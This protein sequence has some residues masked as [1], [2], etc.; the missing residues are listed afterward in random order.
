MPGADN[1][2]DEAHPRVGVWLA[3]SLGLL[4]TLGP[5]GTDTYLASLPEMV[6]E[7][8]S[9]PAQGQLTLTVFLLAMG[10]GSWPP[11]PSSMPAADDGPCCWL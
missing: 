6:D 10:S 5:A 2:V 3:F 1:D 9:T 4:T 7:L 11:G 8:G